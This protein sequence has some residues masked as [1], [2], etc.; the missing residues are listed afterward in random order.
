MSTETRTTEAPND[1][2][3]IIAKLEKARESI[4]KVDSLL[5]IAERGGFNHDDDAEILIEVTRP[6]FGDACEIID[7][8]LTFLEA[9]GR[10]KAEDSDAKP[11]AE[12]DAA[13]P[14][15]HEAAGEDGE[16]TAN[17]RDA[18]TD[19]CCELQNLSGV[20]RAGAYAAEGGG[21]LDSELTLRAVAFSIQA[22][23][24]MVSAIPDAQGAGSAS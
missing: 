16:E 2:A 17:F 18:L 14:A 6:L 9:G 23:S 24:N 5:G 10:D 4:W 11:E 1:K 13:A 3:S 20:C 15:G 7:D 19:I 12:D 8:T 21:S 22:I